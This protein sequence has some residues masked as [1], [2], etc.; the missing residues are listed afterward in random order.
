MMAFNTLS[1]IAA[2]YGRRYNMMIALSVAFDCG[3]QLLAAV[4][5]KTDSE[6]DVPP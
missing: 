4:S 3:L 1:H 5:C 6:D 2:P